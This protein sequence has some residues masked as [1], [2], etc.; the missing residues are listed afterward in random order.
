[1]KNR[2]VFL[3]LDKISGKPL[4][5]AFTSQPAAEQSLN[6]TYSGMG[7]CRFGEFDPIDSMT[8]VIAP[9]GDEFVIRSFPLFVGMT[10]L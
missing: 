10:H 8:E 3:V 9:N 4:E 6:L 5:G 2:Q 7:Q 1:M